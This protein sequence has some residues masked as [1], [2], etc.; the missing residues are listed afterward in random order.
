MSFNQMC[1]VDFKSRKITINGAFKDQSIPYSAVIKITLEKIRNPIRNDN[2]IPF[3]LK[4]FDDAN[5]QFPIDR[6][7]FVPNMPCTW[8]CRR[9]SVD[10]NYCFSCWQDQGDTISFLMTTET[11]STCKNKCDDGW[12]TDG[13]PGKVCQRC[14]SSCKTCVDEGN[15]GDKNECTLCAPGFELRLGRKCVERCPYGTFREGFTCKPCAENCETCDGKANF[16]TSCK[17][18]GTFNFFFENKCYEGCP[19][20]HG[21]LAGKC[22]PCEYPCLECRT[23]AQI[24]K[25]CS[26]EKG[27]SFLFGTTCINECPIGF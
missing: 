7:D 19:P 10:K 26:Q 12:T 17:S 20:R 5:E 16:C 25:T 27:V 24:C 11:A 21:S 6:L 18:L 8:P 14:D 23:E 15:K 9:C 3:A 22:F 4:T 1:A 2:L 13:N